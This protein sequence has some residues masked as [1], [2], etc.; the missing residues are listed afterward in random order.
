M[1]NN[2]NVSFLLKKGFVTCQQKYDNTIGK[3][4]K[5]YQ[6]MHR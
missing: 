4:K 5:N 6:Y 2:F 3:N 1:N